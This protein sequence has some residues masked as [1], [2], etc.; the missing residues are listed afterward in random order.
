MTNPNYVNNLVQY[1]KKNIKK[2]YTVE[3][4]RWAL[5]R[6]GY[7]RVLV[8]KAIE[9]TTKELAIEAP[10]LKDKPVIK[11]QVIDEHGIPIVLKKPWWKR[12][13]GIK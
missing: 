7:S 8:E 3:S 10:V 5:I 4:L 13:F 2:G 6:Q 1:F 11:Y 12:I 9:Q